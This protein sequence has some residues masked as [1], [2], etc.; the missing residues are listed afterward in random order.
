MKAIVLKYPI[1][2]E[3][4]LRV[5][6]GIMSNNYDPEI[7]LERRGSQVIQR[8]IQNALV[9]GIYTSFTRV[10]GEEEFEIPVVIKLH[11]DSADRIECIYSDGTLGIRIPNALRMHAQEVLDVTDMVLGRYDIQVDPVLEMV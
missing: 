10:F 3:D 1:T 8:T 7:S 4:F 11:R 2:G 9:A 5:I 6:K